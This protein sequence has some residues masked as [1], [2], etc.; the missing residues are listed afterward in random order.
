[1][2]RRVDRRLLDGLREL[3]RV[4]VLDVVVDQVGV[5]IAESGQ[6]RLARAVDLLGPVLRRVRRGADPGDSLS[7]DEHG[8]ALDRLVAG[9]RYDRGVVER[10]VHVDLLRLRPTL[11]GIAACGRNTV[12]LGA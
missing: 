8:P 10:D 2:E 5:S 6:D 9:A 7:L 4:G 11:N 12:A 1:M 3:D